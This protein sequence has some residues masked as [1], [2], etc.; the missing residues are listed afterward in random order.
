MFLFRLS[1]LSALVMVHVTARGLDDDCLTC[2]CGAVSGC[3]GNTCREDERGIRVCGQYEI[4]YPYWIDCG[5]LGASW[6]ECANDACCAKVCVMQYLK[7]Y[8]KF[9]TKGRK[10]TCE[11]YA[12]IH[13]GGLFGCRDTTTPNAFWSSVQTCLPDA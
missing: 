2:I 13:K 5:R 6:E 7:R 4:T 12:K 8:G 1:I 9:C 10:P 3:Q 11:D